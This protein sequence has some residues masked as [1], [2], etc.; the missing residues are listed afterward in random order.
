MNHTY[1]KQLENNI[2]ALQAKLGLLRAEAKRNANT[3]DGEKAI[4]QI[5]DLEAQV[6]KLQDEYTKGKGVI[7]G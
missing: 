4:D 7:N 1:L 6:D 5:K 3:I 2:N